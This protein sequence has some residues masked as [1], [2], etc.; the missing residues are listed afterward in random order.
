LS[1]ISSFFAF[2]TVL[3]IS[4]ITALLIAALAVSFVVTG[5]NDYL[6]VKALR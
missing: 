1:P 5:V 3:A 6:I 2:D 4:G